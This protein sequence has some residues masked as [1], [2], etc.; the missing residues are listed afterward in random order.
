MPSDE[1]KRLI[2]NATAQRYRDRIKKRCLEDTDFAE[3]WR[4]KCRQANIRARIKAG[5][6]GL[7]RQRNY[8]RSRVDNMTPDERARYMKSRG[9]ASTKSRLMK[10]PEERRIIH[11][12]HRNAATSRV[13]AQE[14][15]FIATWNGTSIRF[16]NDQPSCLVDYATIDVHVTHIQCHQKVQECCKQTGF[17]MLC[18]HTR[19]KIAGLFDADGCISMY[20][21]GSIVCGISQACNAT[22]SPLLEYIRHMCGTGQVRQHSKGSDKQRRTW[23]WT[24]PKDSLV[25]FLNIIS[26][27]CIIKHGEADMMLDYIEHGGDVSKYRDNLRLAKD[28]RQNLTDI[29]R[30]T[31]AYLAGLITGDGCIRIATVSR[32]IYT[33]VYMK[34]CPNIVQALH[35]KFKTSKVYTPGV[36]QWVSKD[37][38]EIVRL[39]YPYLMGAKA[40]QAACVLNMNN[41]VQRHKREPIPVNNPEIN[42]WRLACKALKKI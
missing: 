15:E 7:Q 8:Y 36:L 21:C 30:V 1:E 12:K 24:C 25:Q 16:K 42:F 13:Q 34:D 39:I 9:E 20:K 31:F 5:E 22:S 41:Y 11:A 23:I 6:W 38:I 32:C 3:R 10:T 35:T 4:E 27:Y 19:Q 33:I 40:L 29:S 37:S 26:N 18:E 17:D 14:Y 2:R 28:N